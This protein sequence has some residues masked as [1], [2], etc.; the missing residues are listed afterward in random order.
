MMRPGRARAVPLLLAGVLCLGPASRP[1]AGGAAPPA[2]PGPSPG[3][4]MPRALAEALPPPITEWLAAWNRVDPRVVREAFEARSTSRFVF[5]PGG[6]PIRIDAMSPLNRRLL[7]FSPDSSLALKPFEFS[8]HGQGGA[9][10]LVPVDPDVEVTLLE[11]RTGLWSTFL[12]CGTPCTHDEAAWLDEASFVVAGSVET[13]TAEP[14]GS[15]DWVVSP[16]IYR[17]S[18]SDST[19][20]VFQGPGVSAETKG[21]PE[22][23]S[24]ATLRSRTFIGGEGHQARDGRK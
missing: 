17:V 24:Y 10:E 5:Q 8:V 19:L 14:A 18:L 13:P 7:I 20:T 9:T 16:V 15:H 11:V 23:R 1:A 2:G 12:K 21:V 6:T 22:L 4:A 3:T